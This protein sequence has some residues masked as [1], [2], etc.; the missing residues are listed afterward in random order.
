[1]KT[2]REVGS[3]LRGLDRKVAVEHSRSGEKSKRKVETMRKGEK[4][5]W[6]N[7]KKKT[8]NSGAKK[9]T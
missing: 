2:N 9:E 7:R 1:V 8:N 3:R 5:K 4:K 6:G